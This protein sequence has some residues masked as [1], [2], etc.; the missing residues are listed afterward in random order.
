MDPRH[1]SSRHGKERIVAAATILL[2]ST[3]SCGPV[4]ADD[5][6]AIRQSLWKFDRTDGGK[7]VEAM[8]CTNPMEGMKKMNATLE[9]S[10]CRF[11]PVKKSWIVY[12]YA[13]DCS[14]RMPTGATINSCSTSVMTVAGENSYK[15]EIDVVTDDRTSKELLVA[16]RTGDCPK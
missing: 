5:L 10:D 2:V 14:M 13:A 12:T 8:K 3:L 15:I 16:Q 7:K 1:R 9:K 4:L 6:P 11:S